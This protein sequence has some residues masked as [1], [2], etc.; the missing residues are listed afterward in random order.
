[1]AEG[2]EK[3]ER[4][5][6][7]A[8]ARARYQMETEGDVE[9]MKPPRVNMWT[10]RASDGAKE[11]MWERGSEERAGRGGKREVEKWIE[12]YAAGI[13]RGRAREKYKATE[14]PKRGR[15]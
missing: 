3:P 7:A 1:M 8:P 4:W 6:P 15:R 5:R 9:A 2:A 14:E 13:M 12:E 10:A 11:R